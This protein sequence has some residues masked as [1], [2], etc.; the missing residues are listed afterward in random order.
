MLNIERPIL[1][2]NMKA[3][4]IWWTMKI[5]IVAPNLNERRFLFTFLESLVDQ[6]FRNFEIIIVDGGSSDGS[7]EMLRRYTARLRMRVLIDRTRNIGYV[8][9][10]GS[11]L[12]QGDLIFN[13]S[14]DTYFVPDLLQKVALIF[15]D[16]EVIAVSGRTL[17]INSGLVSVLAYTAFDLIRYLFT[18]APWPLHK[19][20][21]AGNFTC[22]R[23]DVFRALG[24]FPE[25]K[26]NE[27]GLLGQRIDDF[28]RGQIS[29]LDP[30]RVVFRLDLFVG[31][32]AKR[33]QKKGGLKAMAMYV[34]VFANMLPFL[35]PL[36]RHIERK[37]G[38]IFASRS[39]IGGV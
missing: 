11:F 9:N 21:P 13:T 15:L 39:D 2:P 20:R 30:A 26:I 10:V 5:S 31:H 33:F 1:S 6:T 19:F 18:V 22:I 16:P 37:S 23:N 8:R 38:E 14:T 28:M 35:R 34:Y 17:P 24:G 3:C 25:V 4:W 27:D 32:H 36:F 7:L 12:A 29:E